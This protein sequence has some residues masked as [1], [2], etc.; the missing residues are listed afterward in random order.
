MAEENHKINIHDGIHTLTGYVRYPH[1]PR[2]IKNYEEMVRTVGSNLRNER[3]VGAGR[4]TYGTVYEPVE[5]K[6]HV[7]MNLAREFGLNVRHARYE[8]DGT[9]YNLLDAYPAALFDLYGYVIFG[10]EAEINAVGVSS[11]ENNKVYRRKRTISSIGKK[12]T[13]SDEVRQQRFKNLHAIMQ[14]LIKNNK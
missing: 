3:I 2:S 12:S 11:K 8:T 9:F 10:Q 5:D 13:I 1:K 7:A 4:F 6:R 14:N